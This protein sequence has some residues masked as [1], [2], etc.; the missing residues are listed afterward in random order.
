MT[1]VPPNRYFH[2]NPTSP[3]RARLE[4]A[5]GYFL[6]GNYNESLAA[7]QQAW[8][9]HPREP[10]V[11][12]I[13]AYFHMVRGEYPPAAQAAYQAV[14]FDP[15]N[16]S[17][18]ATL[19]QVYLTFHMMQLAEDTLRV[20][21]ERFPDDLALSTLLA[22]VY[23]RRG[24]NPDGER[25]ALACLAQNPGDAYAKAL[26][27]KFRLSK[28]R[29][30]DAAMLYADV[31]EAYPSRWDYLRDA[32]IALLHV[33]QVSAAVGMLDRSLGLNTDEISIKQHLYLAL[34]MELDRPWYWRLAFVF[35]RQP[36]LGW[37]AIVFG[38]IAT[39]VG[40]GWLTSASSGNGGT[41]LV[42]GQADPSAVLLPFCLCIVGLALIIFPWTGTLL[43]NAK[44]DSLDERLA[45]QL[46]RRL[47]RL[48]EMGES[49]P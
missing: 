37:L 24:L 19:A 5:E 6:A 22:D 17:S 39:L 26:I 9:E 34:R 49:A 33:R 14:V 41:P 36:G 47:E 8:R 25:L 32:G 15:D 40:L 43:A 21:H 38:A 18:Y 13:L 30:L 3:A 10:D 42:A 23:F 27:A 28:G 2:V 29:N 45:L 7:A 12:R 35:F 4:E 1:T 31:V 16:P 44:G 11:Y 20:A 46:D 48:G